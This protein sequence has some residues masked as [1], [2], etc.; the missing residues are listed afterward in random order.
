MLFLVE[1]TRL[2]LFKL[3]KADDSTIIWLGSG[4]FDCCNFNSLPDD[5]GSDYLLF[6]ND[7]RVG[8]PGYGGA[9]VFLEKGYYYPM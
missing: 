8:G 1:E 2:Y 6:A 4:A 9:Y 3:N 7:Y 5:A